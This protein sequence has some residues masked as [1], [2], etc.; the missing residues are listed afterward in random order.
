[1]EGCVLRTL[2]V[3][4]ATRAPH[5]PPSRCSGCWQAG[6]GSGRAQDQPQGGQPSQAQPANIETVQSTT[7][8]SST[9]FVKTDKSRSH[10]QEVKHYRSPYTPL[11]L[12]LGKDQNSTEIQYSVLRVLEEIQLEATMSRHSQGGKTV[13]AHQGLLQP[14]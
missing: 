7:H 3:C 2:L 13:R 1:M 14:L 12:G 5:R 6:A 10:Y 4:L 9:V 8:E 11:R